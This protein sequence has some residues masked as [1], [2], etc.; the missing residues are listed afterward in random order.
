MKIVKRHIFAF[1]CVAVCA[2][3]AQKAQASEAWAELLEKYAPQIQAAERGKASFK[4]SDELSGKLP[5]SED[6]KDL[7]PSS[8]RVFAVQVAS[9]A[10]EADAKE[11]AANLELRGL[12]SFY[13]SF[14]V[15]DQKW[16][17]V[18]LGLFD[19]RASAE[20]FRIKNKQVAD[21]AKGLVRRI[22][23]ET[24]LRQ[25]ARLRS[26]SATSVAGLTFLIKQ[27]N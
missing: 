26:K 1:G 18:N 23:K 11:L 8:H 2:A 25:F 21:L 20:A 10:T 3:T 22:P 19:D 6:K 27:Q 24:D 14:L 4:A 13:F 16:Y 7:R 17:R 9:F 5:E 15:G 12:P